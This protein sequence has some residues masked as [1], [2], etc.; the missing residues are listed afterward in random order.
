MK[1]LLILI[2]FLSVI[3]VANAQYVQFGF[4]VDIAFDQYKNA[5]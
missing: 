5:F 2:A 1:K 3:T 4:T